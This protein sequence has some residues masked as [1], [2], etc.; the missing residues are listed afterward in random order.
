LEEPGELEELQG[1]QV[2]VVLRNELVER[3][4]RRQDEQTS[5]SNPRVSR[6]EYIRANACRTHYLPELEEV[7][8]RAELEVQQET[9][10]WWEEQ[11]VEMSKRRTA[12]EN[13]IERETKPVHSRFRGSLPVQE[14]CEVTELGPVA[15]RVEGR[16][17][18]AEPMQHQQGKQ[19]EGESARHE[20]F[21]RKKNLRMTTCKRTA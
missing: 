18:A 7:K 11:A 19:K 4:G 17:G 13:H 8:E 12:R 10:I 21:S 9:R 20:D 16:E 6:S 15:Q 14:V 1:E 5:V 3:A 2:R